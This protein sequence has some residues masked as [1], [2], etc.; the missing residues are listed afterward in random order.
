VPNLGPLTLTLSPTAAR[1]HFA[2][3]ARDAAGN[4]SS[5]STR[6]SIPQPPSFPRSGNDT[7]APTAPG[8]A[9]ISR[10]PGGPAVLT[11]PAATDNIGVVEYHVVVVSNV[12]A[13]N[14]VAK[15]A[16][17]SAPVPSGDRVFIIAYDASWNS[18]T[19]PIVRIGSTTPPPTP[20][21]GQ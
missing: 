12:D 9:T 18:A 6:T 4:T 5:L 2:V 21:A 16:T 17:N 20:A 19:G 1:I 13:V 10:P 14:V 15:V 11:W 8:A 3:A 7:V